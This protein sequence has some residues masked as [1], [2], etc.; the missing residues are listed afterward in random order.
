MTARAAATRAELL[1]ARRLADRVDRGASLL[2]RKREALVRALVPLA[3]PAAEARRAIAETA[4]A[5]YR[6]ELDALAERGAGDVGATGWP[7]R[8][9]DVELELERV[10]GLAVP[11]LRVATPVERD[12]AVRGTAPGPTGPALF[13]AANRFEALIAQLL[14]GVAREAR[15]RALGDA[16]ARASRQL[17]TLEQRV[18]PELAAQIAATMR[19]LDERDRE[20]Q[21][22]LRNLRTK[23]ASHRN[24]CTAGRS[25]TGTIGISL[26]CDEAC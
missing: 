3:R 26:E 19:A 8:A 17:H 7:P 10:W 15:V 22:R 13:E 1:R 2:R 5:A 4:A 25:A 12:L 23:S 14:E 20:D 24:P 16:L 21:T 6:A 9:I 11:A 18:A